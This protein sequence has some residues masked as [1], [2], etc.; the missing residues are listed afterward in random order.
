VINISLGPSSDSDVE[1]E[2]LSDVGTYGKQIGRISDAPIVLFAHFHPQ[3]PLTPEESAAIG[4]LREM[5][6]E[7]A[8]VKE[9]PGRTALCPKP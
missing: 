8:Q 4:A 5:L 6:N 7:V 1:H 3:S 2:L 9:K